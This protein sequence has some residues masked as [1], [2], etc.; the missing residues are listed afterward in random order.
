MIDRQSQE[1]GATVGHLKLRRLPQVIALQRQRTWDQDRRHYRCILAVAGRPFIGDERPHTMNR[2]VPVDAPFECRM[3][4]VPSLTAIGYLTREVGDDAVLLLQ[5]RSKRRRNFRC[6]SDR[7]SSPDRNSG[8]PEHVSLRHA[9]GPFPSP[10]FSLS[11]HL[12]I[13][14]KGGRRKDRRCRQR[15]VTSGRRRA[16]NF[17]LRT[18]KSS[19][20]FWQFSTQRKQKIDDRPFSCFWH[21]CESCLWRRF[22]RAGHS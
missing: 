20:L 15:G 7:T 11:A 12:T 8:K 5:Q 17:V 22:S 18:R 10:M 6:K 16:S 21:A 19:S 9:D 1:P 3:L 14:Y 4:R 2:G 13:I